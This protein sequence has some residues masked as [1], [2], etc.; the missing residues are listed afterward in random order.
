[1][2]LKSI[3][4]LLLII[5]FLSSAQMNSSFDFIVGIEQSYRS[6]SLAPD[7]FVPINIIDLRDTNESAKFNWRIGFNYNKRLSNKFFLK[8]GIRLASVG[9]KGEKQTD[10]RWPSEISQEGYMYDPSLFHE[11]QLVYNYWFIEVPLVARYEFSSKKFSPFLEAGVSPSY[12]LTTRTTTITDLG[13]STTSMRG[14]NSPF[15]NL[16]LVGVLSLGANYDITD[17]MQLFGQV[18]YRRHF[19]KL[20]VAP[21]Q[22]YL[23]NYGLEFGIRLGI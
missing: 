16:H 4:I 1:M 10:L 17:Q 11:L 19:S 18:I 12:Y 21:I 20:V 15:T 6:L 3:A 23:Y 9:Y 14:G 22:E 5:P 2:K 8:S 13:T 7:A